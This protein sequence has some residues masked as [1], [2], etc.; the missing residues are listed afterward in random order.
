[1]SICCVVMVQIRVVIFYLKFKHLFE[2]SGKSSYSNVITKLQHDSLDGLS[3]CCSVGPR[4]W[5]RL[6][7]ICCIDDH[8]TKSLNPNNF[9]LVFI[10]P[11]KYPPEQYRLSVNQVIPRL[12]L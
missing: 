12:L 8:V 7:Y 10:D 9:T 6:K 2:S 4:L 11:V 3:V 5:S 1:M